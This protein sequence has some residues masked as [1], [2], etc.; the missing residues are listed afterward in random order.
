MPTYNQD[1]KATSGN[2]GGGKEKDDNENKGSRKGKGPKPMKGAK[3]GIFGGFREKMKNRRQA[4][5]DL[6]YNPVVDKSHR[7]SMNSEKSDV[8]NF[9]GST[10]SVGKLMMDDNYN[11]GNPAGTGPKSSLTPGQKRSEELRDAHS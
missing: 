4:K 2:M 7:N 11:I 9:Q 3:S 6:K 1:M 8:K 5:D 10:P